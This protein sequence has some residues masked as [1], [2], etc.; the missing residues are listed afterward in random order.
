MREILAFH[1]Q[2][3]VTD[4][5]LFAEPDGKGS[6][7]LV[8][9][10]LGRYKNLDGTPVSFVEDTF[11][12]KNAEMIHMFLDGALHDLRSIEISLNGYTRFQKLVAAAARSVPWGKTVSYRQ[13]AR[14]SGNP[15]AVRAAANVM[16]NNRY[17][18][19]V[20]CHRIIYNDGSIGGFSG[21]TG[22][23][24]IQLKRKLLENEGVYLKNTVRVRVTK[25]VS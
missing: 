3:P 17:A 25:P 24:M 18:L 4:V 22:G 21:Q 23:R 16:R 2:H 13:L 9:V 11:L 10:R 15:D 7:P 19:V 1:I 14:M 8:S 6:C 20:P 12:K 5:T